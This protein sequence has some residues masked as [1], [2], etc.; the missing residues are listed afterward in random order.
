MMSSSMPPAVVTRQSTLRCCS[1]Q[2]IVSRVPAETRLDVQPRKLVARTFAR[3]AGSRRSSSS[4]A[5]TG[6]S[7]RRHARMRLTS[8]TAWPKLVAWKPVVAYDASSASRL[9][10]SLKS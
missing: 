2:R 8:S 5:A 9:T 7:E 1:S 6:T 10:P 3:A 4:S